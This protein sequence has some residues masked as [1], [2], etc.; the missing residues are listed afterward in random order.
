MRKKLLVSFFGLGYLPIAPGTWGSFG[1][2]VVF[3]AIAAL[4]NNL[5][6]H[7][8]LWTAMVVLTIIASIIGIALGRWSCEFYGAKDPKPFVL[9]EVA[10]MWIS[11]LFLPFAGR[12]DL[13]ILAMVQFFLFRV[14][15]VIKPPPA[16]QSE[17]LP[18]GWGIVTDDLIAGVYA[19]VVGQ[20]VFRYIL[21]HLTGG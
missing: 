8:V 9:D 20:V 11:V 5:Q 6:T 16:R 14:F 13:L 12:G 4:V 21:P 18:H 15:D 10:G 3:F 7:N 17:S 19:N 2:A 1:A